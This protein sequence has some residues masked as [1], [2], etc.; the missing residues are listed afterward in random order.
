SAVVAPGTGFLLNNELTDFGAPGTANAAAPYKRPRSSMSPT[1]VVR[2]GKPILVTGGA[3]GSLI[4][5]GVVQAVLNTVE[6]GLDLPQAIDWPRIDDQGSSSLRIEDSRLDPRVLS[7][8]QARG[9]I[10]SSG[11]WGSVRRSRRRGGSRGPRGRT[12]SS[13]GRCCPRSSCSRSWPTPPR[14]AT[15][16]TRRA[17]P[18][19]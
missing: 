13:A 4:I 2:K 7:D 14:D 17:S 6:Y 12:A 18:T 5:M 16:C 19:R 8:L 11:R 3:G 1:I 15:G 9:W 10:R